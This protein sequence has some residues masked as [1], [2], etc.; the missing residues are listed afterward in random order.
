MRSRSVTIPFWITDVY[1]AYERRR[2]VSKKNTA[3]KK[4]YHTKKM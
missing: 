2:V 3:Y 4:V 1:V